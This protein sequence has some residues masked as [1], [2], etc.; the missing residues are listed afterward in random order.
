MQFDFGKLAM[1]MLVIEVGMLFTRW[2]DHSIETV[3]VACAIGIIVA[4]SVS[5]QPV[6]N[7]SDTEVDDDWTA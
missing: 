5:E 7:G 6:Q 2:T 4:L 1:G 3:L